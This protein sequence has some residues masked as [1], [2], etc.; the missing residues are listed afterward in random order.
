MI[1]TKITKEEL[2]ASLVLLHGFGVSSDM[3]VEIAIH[4]ALN[5]IHCYLLDWRGFG[6]SGGPR[7][8]MISVFDM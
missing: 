5:G 8:G 2:K 4:Y 6:L 1:D 3:M 7:A